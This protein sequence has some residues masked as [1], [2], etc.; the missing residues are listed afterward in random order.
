MRDGREC[1]AYR[2]RNRFSSYR[3]SGIC[4]FSRVRLWLLRDLRLLAVVIYN[5]P[6]T[7]LVKFDLD[8]LN[9]MLQ[10]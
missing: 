1:R 7:Y 10:T 6:S 3:K 9:P 2:C 4:G 8:D 5:E